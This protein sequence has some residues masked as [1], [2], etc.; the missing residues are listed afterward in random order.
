MGLYEEGIRQAKEGSEICERLWKGVGQAQCLINLAFLMHDDGQLD[1]AE[2]AASRAMDLLP[3]KGEQ[4]LVCRGH[5]ILGKIYH[6]KGEREKAIHHF[7]A[8]HEIASSLDLNDEL[9]WNYFS[10]AL[11]FSGEGKLDEAHAHI[12]RA[13]SHAANDA[14]NL[15]RASQMQARFWDK[16]RKFGEA[17]SEALCALDG[18]EKL[19]AARDAENTR[20]LPEQTDR[21][22]RGDGRSGDAW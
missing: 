13:R 6:P 11:L 17:K 21:D 18:F 5:R 7:K 14:Y 4:F 8:A 20:G 16:Q 9:F 22:A 10:V 1:A 2:E 12:E 15:A 19:G 3:E